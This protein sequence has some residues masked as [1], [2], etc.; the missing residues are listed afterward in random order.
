[1]DTIALPN[2]TLGILLPPPI[3]HHAVIPQN[4]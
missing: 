1:M 3:T 2:H 4:F